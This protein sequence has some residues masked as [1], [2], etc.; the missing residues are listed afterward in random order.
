MGFSWT[1]FLAQIVNLFVLVWLMKRFLY[2]PIVTVIAKR[3]AYI[4]GK[5]KNAE[6]AE[7]AAQKQ[8]AALEKQARQWNADHQKRLEA[9]YAEIADLRREQTDRVHL[10]AASLRQK[11]QDDLNR[12]T[13]SLRLE[14]RNMMA[15]NFL[16]LSHKVLADFSGLT[17]MAQV[18]DLFRKKVTDL[19]AKER[20]GFRQQ[21]SSRGRLVITTSAK[22]NAATEKSLRSFLVQQFEQDN[23]V[24]SVDPDLIL[25]I[26]VGIGD[27]VLA[28]SLKDY[29]DTLE[30]NL[31]AALAGLI[32]KE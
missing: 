12:E 28:W 21:A 19:S 30:G 4:E 18:L 20:Q 1:T 22:L 7:K 11:M 25:G 5:V 6:A 15:Q 9:V 10:E 3:Q 14:I 23:M 2:G 16:T 32:V 27:T 29:L 31:N 24:F 8:Q 26:E 13:A 17:P